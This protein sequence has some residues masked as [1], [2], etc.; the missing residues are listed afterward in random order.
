MDL[1]DKRRKQSEI[2]AGNGISCS[3]MDASNVLC[4]ED[5]MVNGSIK[6]KTT[7]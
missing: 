3:V 4:S 5:E 6:N 7:E 1:W 2:V